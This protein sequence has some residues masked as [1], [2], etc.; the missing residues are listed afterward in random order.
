[1][2]TPFFPAW[3]SK[4]AALGR[5]VTR[6]RSVAEIETEV[7]R[8]LP[9]DLLK[10]PREGKGSRDRIYS[11]R[12]TF[13]C[14]LW[15]VLQPRTPCR[16][17]VRKVQAECETSQRKIDESSSGYC[18][19]RSRLPIELLDNTL[20]HTATRAE[21]KAD[22][23]IP[24]WRRNVKVVDVTSAQMPDTAANCKRYHYPTGQKKGCGFPV[25]R[26]S[27]LFSL[28]CGT[29]SHITTA[30]CYTGELVMFK[31]LWPALKPGDILLGDRM[32][33]CFPVLASLSSRSVDVVARLHQSRNL[34]LRRAPKLGPDDWLVSFQK[35]YIV[36]PY[37]SKREWKKLPDNIHVR[38]IRSRI[39]MKGFRT[40][41]IW[42]VTTLL[43]S[44]RYTAED[45]AGLYLR[46]WQM[47]LTFR[48]LKT[49]MAMDMFICKTPNMVEKEL[50]MYLVAYNCLRTLMLESALKHVIPQYRISFKGTI[51][52]VRS[53]LPAMLRSAKTTRTRLRSRLLAILAEDALPYR[54]GRN[55]PRAIKRRPKQYPMLTAPRHHFKEV[56]HKGNNPTGKCTQTILT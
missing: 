7:A 30:A 25:M 27:A 50:R 22:Y 18:Q 12:R 44:K 48:D 3:R 11:R 23:P 56:P 47:E 15:Q 21:Q 16:A 35:G 39:S 32:Y 41:T 33:G 38:I 6:R 42:I 46:R 24:D 19:A 2:N 8:L 52:T 17:V 40:R 37:M 29:I 34:D 53:F 13:W 5:S 28:A 54:P 49:T 1:M 26:I 4:L 55:E 10:R 36:P 51:D 43:D 14:F 45:I 20:H 31:V 9:P